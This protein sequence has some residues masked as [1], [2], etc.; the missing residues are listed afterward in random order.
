MFLKKVILWKR[1]I[2]QSTE[3]VGGVQIFSAALAT[4]RCSKL[5]LISDHLMV[6]KFYSGVHDPKECD[7]RMKL[8]QRVCIFKVWTIYYYNLH[9]GTAWDVIL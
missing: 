9:N 3:S 8:T 2:H 1:R 5:G 6:S 4:C 7:L